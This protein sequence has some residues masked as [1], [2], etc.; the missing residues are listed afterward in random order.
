MRVH[1]MGKW[2]CLRPSR[3]FK[4]AEKSWSDTSINVDWHFNII[5]ENCIHLIEEKTDLNS[6]KTSLDYSKVFFGCLGSISFQSGN[7]WGKCAS[8]V[9]SNGITWSATK[10]FPSLDKW[11]PS[12]RN[13][14][15]FYNTHKKIIWERNNNSTTLKT[16]QPLS[17]LK[18]N[19]INNK[20]N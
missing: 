16:S 6:F 10:R 8:L 14:S 19:N 12:H 17:E 9:S 1:V 18:Q 2:T 4:I 5:P 20:K 13:D 3:T 7:M 11:R 15:Q